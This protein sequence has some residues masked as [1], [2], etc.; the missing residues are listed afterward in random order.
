MV[1]VCV[2]VCVSCSKAWMTPT[3]SLSMDVT[4][5]H[6]LLSKLSTEASEALGEE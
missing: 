6:F 1:C 3:L 5:P 4:E 2:C